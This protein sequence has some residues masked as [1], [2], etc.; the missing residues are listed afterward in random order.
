MKMGNQ[1]PQFGG[2][3]Y[4]MTPVL[5]T[6]RY[7]AAYARATINACMYR[8]F[9]QLILGYL[10]VDCLHKQALVTF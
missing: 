7:M 1:G 3:Y 2:P 10:S 4:H 5:R 9:P 8:I 6:C